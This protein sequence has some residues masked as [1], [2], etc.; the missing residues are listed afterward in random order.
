MLLPS[1]FTNDFT[2]DDFFDDFFNAPARRSYMPTA[3]MKCDVKELD[4]SYQI[5]MQLPG[6]DKDDIEVSVDKGYL[7]VSAS[8]KENK[9]DK[10][11]GKYIRK[12]CFTGSCQRS[13]YVGDAVKGEDIGAAFTNGILSLTVPKAE[14]L[15][16]NE[17]KQLVHIEG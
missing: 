11:A 16:Q 7:T 15:P 6:Y 13:F 8:H 3:S 14:A 12:E 1:V 10:E 2:N 17:T 9:E 4:Q 5:D